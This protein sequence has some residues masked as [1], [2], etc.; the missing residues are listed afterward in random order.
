MKE[1]EENNKLKK[2]Y[3]LLLICFLSLFIL[4]GLFSL[5]PSRLNINLSS[6]GFTIIWLYF[7][8]LFFVSVLFM[9][10]RTERV[11]YINYISY[12]E[13]LDATKEE[14]KAFAY[15]HLRIFCIASIAFILYTIISIQYQFS[16][17]MDIAV[18]V[19]IIVIAALI[20]IPI[21]LKERDNKKLKGL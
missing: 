3:D 1:L 16:N 15:K 18:F 19:F 9:I 4:A 20:T 6:K 13:A 17:G 14:R 11:Y 10:Y 5:L 21:R 2:S 8:N 12:K 7:L